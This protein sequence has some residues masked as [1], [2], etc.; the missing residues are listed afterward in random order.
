M[1]TPT[2]H[3]STRD[4]L[5]RVEPESLPNLRFAHEWL[6]DYRN[7]R[8]GALKPN[9]VITGDARLRARFYCLD[10]TAY[11][12]LQPGDGTAYR[13]IAHDLTT[14]QA[15]YLR[16][17]AEARGGHLTMAEAREQARTMG[18]SRL[19]GGDVLLALPDLGHVIVLG[20]YGPHVPWYVAEK[21]RHPATSVIVAAWATAFC[22]TV[23]ALRGEA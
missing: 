22:D 23:L 4:G 1:T 16:E 7:D 14:V 5:P 13:M 18:P 11:T 2:E 9:E 20:L 3:H 19:F 12:D 6:D 15:G 8:A 10:G 21:V 17:K